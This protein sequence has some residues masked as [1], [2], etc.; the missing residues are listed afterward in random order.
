MRLD[1]VLVALFPDFSRSRLQKWIKNGQVV[2]DN[3]QRVRPKH[4]VMGGER[5]EL[6]I[7]DD[8][9]SPWLAENIPLEIVFEDEQILVVNKPA[10]MVVHPAAGNR[11]GTLCNALLHYAPEIAVVPRVGVVHRLDKDT[12]GLLVIAKTV[13][14]HKKLVEQL[15]QRTV[16]REYQALCYGVMTAGGTVDA[17]IGRHAS[18]RLRMAVVPNGK[19]AITHYRVQRRFTAHTLVRVQLETGRTHQIRVHMAYVRYPLVGDY[20]YGGRARVH[21][22]CTEAFASALRN[23]KRQAL[24]ATQLGF[25]HPMENQWMQWQVAMPEDMQGLVALAQQDNDHTSAQ[26]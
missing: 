18:S 9:E 4:C 14:A 10:G 8:E 26:T 25:T 3:Q 1:Q 6:A 24:H 16:K 23:F 7:M 2:V 12:S 20:S 17:S 13:V 22:G 21:S 5:V 19:M 15:Q 11:S